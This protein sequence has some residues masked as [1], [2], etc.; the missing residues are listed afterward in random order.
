[1]LFGAFEARSDNI[2]LSGLRKRD[3]ER[4]L[5]LLVLHHGRPVKTDALAQT[6]WAASGSLDILHQAASHLRR[7]LAEQAHRLQSPKGT[8]ALDL[9]GARVDVVDF[10]AAVESGEIQS[11]KTAIALYRR[12][13]LLEG[14]DEAKDH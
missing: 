14:W 9:A 6:L 4:L 11:L 2:T 7:V 3:G 12:G 8:L 10:D 13:L 5:P 1:M